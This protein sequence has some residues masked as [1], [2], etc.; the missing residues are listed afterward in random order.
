MQ[1]EAPTIQVHGFAIVPPIAGRRRFRAILRLILESLS[2]ARGDRRQ[3]FAAAVSGL[4]D[5][6]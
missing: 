4:D 2:E 6:G 5:H 1:A 3:V